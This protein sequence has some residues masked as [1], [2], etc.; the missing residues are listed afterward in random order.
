MEDRPRAMPAAALGVGAL[1]ST[2]AN[3]G[4]VT[5]RKGKIH[6]LWVNTWGHRPIQT[7]SYLPADAVVDPDGDREILILSDDQ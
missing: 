7:K 3:R 6:I 2:A 1:V 5:H 4:T